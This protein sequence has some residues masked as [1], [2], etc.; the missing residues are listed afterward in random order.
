MGG[1]YDAVDPALVF[2]NKRLIPQQ[3]P[4]V[5]FAESDTT[6]PVLKPD[7]RAKATAFLRKSMSVPFVTPPERCQ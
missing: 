1:V 4:L 2:K 3:S 5:Y 6:F 7:S